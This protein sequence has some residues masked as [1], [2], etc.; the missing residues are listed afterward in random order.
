[1]EL[2]EALPA[3]FGVQAAAYLLMQRVKAA[4]GWSRSPSWWERGG[5][6]RSFQHVV[7][8]KYLSS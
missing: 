1:M 6:C 8:V 4:A 7:P 5:V 3:G 2:P